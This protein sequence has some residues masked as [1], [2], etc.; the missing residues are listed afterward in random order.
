[1]SF[2]LRSSKLILVLARSRIA[3]ETMSTFLT[4]PRTAEWSCNT[5]LHKVKDK[6]VLLDRDGVVNEDVGAPGVIDTDNFELTRNATSAIGKLHRNG[7]KVVLVTNQSC[8]GKGLITEQDL[9]KIHKHMETL[10][11]RQDFDAKLDR[12]YCCTSTDTNDPNRKPNPGMML[13]AIQD[14]AVEQSGCIMVGDTVTDLQAA[15]APGVG[16]RILVSTGYGIS[17]MGHPWLPPDTL[18]SQ[19][20]TAGNNDRRSAVERL[21][22]SILPFHYVKDLAAAVDL[23]LRTNDREVQ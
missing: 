22:R 9:V 19:L 12:V 2:W 21:P 13:Q 7:Y 14:F 6:L 3:V 8:V 17:T 15:A 18:P 10:L 4:A 16:F 20:I 11:Q 23:I 1:M 5:S